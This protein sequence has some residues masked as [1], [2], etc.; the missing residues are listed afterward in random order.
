MV[1]SSW[2]VVFIGLR[3][4]LYIYIFTHIYEHNV[5]NNDNNNDIPQQ[6]KKFYQQ[7]G[8]EDTKSYQQVKQN[9]FGV[10]YGNQKNIAKSRMDKQHEKRV[11][12]T[13]RK[14]EDENT[15]RFTPNSTKNT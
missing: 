1:I 5:N 4:Y 7:V 12:R 11:R 13:R 8:E 15:H 2:R 6:R 9:N 10:K 14:T 3:L